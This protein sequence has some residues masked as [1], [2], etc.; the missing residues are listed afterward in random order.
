MKTIR[1]ISR[2]AVKPAHVNQGLVLSLLEKV[3]QD[4]LGQLVGR[5]EEEE[6]AE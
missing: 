4:L 1:V 5:K 2:G 3:L 6:P